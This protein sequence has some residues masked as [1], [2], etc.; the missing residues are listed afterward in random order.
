MLGIYVWSSKLPGTYHAYCSTVKD[1]SSLF[2]IACLLDL[3]GKIDTSDYKKFVMWCDV[4]P[5]YRSARFITFWIAHLCKLYG[6]ESL[7]E[8]FAEHHG[9]GILDG[10][11]G[12]MA[13][14]LE[15]IAKTNVVAS[16]QDYCSLM[17]ARAD[18]HCRENPKAIRSVCGFH[19]NS[20]A[21]K[22]FRKICCF[23]TKSYEF[24]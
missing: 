11:F 19:M 16:L 5:H 6:V 23:L 9:K 8:L 14:W 24:L 1:Q 17:A 20:Y 22:L 2:T 7:L 10:F 18:Q 3:L 12:R 13:H 15:A 21:Y 4:G